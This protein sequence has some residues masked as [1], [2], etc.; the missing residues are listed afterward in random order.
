[1]R[2]IMLDKYWHSMSWLDTDMY[3][4]HAKK[5][6]LNNLQWTLSPASTSAHS[7]FSLQI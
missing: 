3:T 7:R 2:Q 4:L 5:I 6:D 1:M